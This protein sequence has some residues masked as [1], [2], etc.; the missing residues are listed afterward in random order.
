MAKKP[1]LI[2][3]GSDN[4][5]GVHPQILQ[6]LLDVSEKYAPSYDTDPTSLEL[7]K[8]IQ[9]NWKAVD[10]HLVF[11][12]TAANVLCLSAA[13][14]SFHSV[15]CTDV[16]HLYESECGAPEKFV[17]CKLI[18][19][20]HKDGK[21]S[22]ADVKAALIRRGDQHHNQI[23]MVSITQ[24]TE[25]GTV[26]SLQELT[27]LRALCDQEKLYLHIDGARLGNACAA[28]DCDFSKIL[29]FAD[30][31]TVGG[32]KNGLLFG[33]LVILNRPELNENFRFRRKQAMQLPS[34]TRFLAHAFLTYLT[35]PL[36]ATPLA[37]APLWKDIAQ[38]QLA[39]AQYLGKKLQEQCGI[40]PLYPVQ[41]NAVFC[42]IPQEWIKKLREEFFFYVWDE[43]TFECRLMTS[44][45]TTQEEV[46]AFIAKIE[47]LK[48]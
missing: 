40:A 15:V 10:S 29:S 45:C 41:S 24:P 13:L 33:E 20:P 26:Y 12:G 25:L 35:A 18:P 16:A 37:E 32:T 1:S 36:L 23:K 22:V 43:K 2:S 44:F 17:G 5:S 48:S 39:M 38:K 9:K 34:K 14:E 42:L 6:S 11:N 31:A 7:K 28:L 27:E 46:D 21:L 47:T 19:I 3:F 30:V 4:H 8:W